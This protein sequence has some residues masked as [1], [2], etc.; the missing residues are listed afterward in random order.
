MAQ[1]ALGWYVSIFLWLFCTGI[2]IPP[3]PEEAGIIYAAGVAA[4]HPEVHWWL[5]W[6]V[7][8]LG[9]LCA[10]LVLYGIGRQW[11]PQLFEHRWVN[12]LIKPQRRQRIERLFREHGVKI[13]LSARFLPP[14]RTGVFIIAGALR[15][16]LPTFVLADLIYG[17]FGVG[18][19]FF[20]SAFVIN[21][22]HRAGYWLLYVLGAAAGAYGLY[23]FYGYL[24]RREQRGDAEP[25]VSVLELPV[26]E[27][28]QAASQG[29]SVR[30]TMHPG[31]QP[32]ER[33]P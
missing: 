5:A 18:I 24:Q 1:E 19:F 2:G 17:T 11:G 16:S 30:P 32:A 13:L 12:R 3:C 22:I 27:I 14:L 9:I 4:L 15:F 23:W 28:E 31:Q 33:Q 20:G 29:E 25:P 8:S 6:P 10:D 26:E 21:L 7:T